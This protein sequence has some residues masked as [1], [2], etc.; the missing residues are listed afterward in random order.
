[1]TSAQPKILIVDDEIKNQRLLDLLL[2]AE[3]YARQ[4]ASNGS[5]ALAS[6]L[7]DP[8]DL[9]L[10]D[11]MMPDMDGYEVARKLK[12]EPTTSNIPI[13]M[14]TAQLDNAARI[15]GLD[16][17]AE[18]FLTKPVERAELWLRVRNLLRLKAYGDLLQSYSTVLEKEVQKRSADLQR[19][20][21][22]MDAT[23]DAIM[24]IDRATMQFVEVNQ[25]AVKMFGYP[26]EELMQMGIWQMASRSR[27]E[28]EDLYDLVIAGEHPAAFQ[29]MVY[30]RKDGT[31]L[32]VEID[33]HAQK[34]DLEWIIVVVVRDVTERREAQE[35][36]HHL[37]HYDPLTG[38]PNRTLVYQTLRK[39]LTQ[40]APSHWQVGVLVVDLDNFKTVNDTLGHAIG[41]QLLDQFSSRLAQCVEVRDTVGR[42]G[43]DEFALIVLMDDAEKAAGQVAARIAEALK[44]P[45]SLQGHEI[46]LTASIG[47]AV[48]PSDTSDAEALMKFADTALYRAKQAGPGTC[49]Y[50]TAQMNAEAVARLDLEMALRKAIEGN[51]FV[52]Y[53]QPKVDLKTSTVVGLEALLRWNRPGHGLVPPCDFIPLLEETGMIVRV[54]SWVIAEACRQMGEW[55]GTRFGEL[56]VSVN[57]SGRQF[58]EGD[59]EADIVRALETNGLPAN[60]L[61]IELTETSLMSNADDT[62]AL[63][64]RLR[65]LGVEISIDDFGT[66]Y[67]NL[68]YL[69]RFPIDKLKI[70]IAFIREITLSEDGAAIVL[71]I[72]R[73]AHS[74]KLQVIAEGVESI[75]ERDFLREHD[76]DYIQGY[77][78]SPPLAVSKL[79]IVL[80]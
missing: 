27:Q 44:E 18:E 22:A 65:K 5:E 25:T 68:A 1:M 73:M 19:F 66:G 33:R 58:V 63:M 38:L 35:R 47:I 42:L 61:E 80:N 12:G 77:F 59:L 56:Q 30:R 41:D 13:I 4:F 17:G 14:L 28:M 79:G 46:T 32:Q 15:K 9:I 39:V 21:V 54:G 71:A 50:F 43:G 62:I 49:R 23:A 78:F 51:E 10:L 75:G 72:I 53:Y 26:R 36:L 64:Q 29:D 57:I 31:P 11:I 69:R 60:K 76:C 40:T 52:L 55:K 45:F 70:D 37:A 2:G 7:N 6:V 8:P 16:A 24:L 67:S 34:S 3:G 74:L 48:F 20:R